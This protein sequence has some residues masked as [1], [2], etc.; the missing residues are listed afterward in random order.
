MVVHD[1]ASG[2]VVDRIAVPNGARPVAIDQNLVYYTTP[3]GAFAWA[4]PGREPTRLEQSGLLDVASATRVY[5]VGGLDSD[6]RP[7]GDR[8]EMVQ[9]FFNVS[10]RRVGEGARLSPGGTWVLSR[11][12]G[13]G[14]PGDPYR[15]LLYDARS[16][17]RLPNGLRPGEVAVDAA[18]GQQNDVTYLVA[19]TEDLAAGAD[20]GGNLSPVLILRTC[21]LEPTTCSDVVPVPRPGGH[22][23]LAH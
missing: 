1:R 13:A 19:R 11:S 20:L 6:G 16:G 9:S 14:T 17:D 23:M 10:F 15:P 4:P 2:D 5:Q 22:P 8:V 18:F 21:Q 7:T 3:H 12:P